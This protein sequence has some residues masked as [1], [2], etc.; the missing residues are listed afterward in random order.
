MITPQDI[1]AFDQ[2]KSTVTT[3]R[4]EYDAV[5]QEIAATEKLLIE[6]P[7]L[8]VPAADLKAAMSDFIDARG[9]AYLD[10]FVK[11][12]IKDF[13]THSMSGFAAPV[14]KTGMPL[15]FKELENAIAGTGGAISRA[16]L[17]TTFEKHQFNDIAL[18][19]FF[20]AQVKAGLNAVM[21]TMTDA[22]LGYDKISPTQ[23]GTDRST[24]RA[25]IQDAQNKLSTLRA[26]KEEIADSLRQ[27]GVT[28]Q[29]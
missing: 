24:R 6:L 10:E 3:M 16:Q 12:A 14:S 1:K 28:I 17:V 26:R 21:D 9:Q 2:V 23:I 19:A 4:T 22:D 8:P 20:G 15:S 18:Y 27:L 11:P 13:A 5:C 7:L 29:G 25:A